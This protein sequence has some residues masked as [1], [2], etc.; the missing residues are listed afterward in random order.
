M[1]TKKTTTRIGNERSATLARRSLLWLAVFLP[2]AAAKDKKKKGPPAQAVLAGTVFRGVGFAFPGV[3]VVAVPDP[4]AGKKLW[5]AISDSRGEYVLRVPAGPASYNISVEVN[6][7]APQRKRIT[8]AADE[9]LDFN[10]LLE[11]SGDKA[12]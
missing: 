6:G 1:K 9:R 8:F 4:P 3:A 11:P 5:R 2:G 7:Y 12:K 10:F